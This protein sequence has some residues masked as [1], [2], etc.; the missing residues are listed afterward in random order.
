MTTRRLVS[1]REFFPENSCGIT[2]W[3]HE[4]I[5]GFLYKGKFSRKPSSWSV[6]KIPV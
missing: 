1:I 2:L 5:K 3:D 4:K 6:K